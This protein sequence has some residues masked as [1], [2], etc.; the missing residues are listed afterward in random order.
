MLLCTAVYARYY[1]ANISAKR[2]TVD[3]MVSQEANSKLAD[4]RRIFGQAGSK[5]FGY[6]KSLLDAVSSG[7][8]RAEQW[9]EYASINV[10]LNHCEMVAV[11]IGS[12]ALDEGMYKKSNRSLYVQA[13]DRS[14][15]Y[16]QY[17]RSVK[18]QPSMYEHFEALAKNWTA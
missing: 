4:D 12:G 17:A 11:A 10:Y 16:I 18:A 8:A 15:E 6:L 13:W 5:G 9:S 7:S 3:F 1:H 14:K 2:A